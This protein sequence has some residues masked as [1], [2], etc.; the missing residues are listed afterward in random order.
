MCVVRTCINLLEERLK[1]LDG[2]SNQSEP[3]LSIYREHNDSKIKPKPHILKEHFD[4]LQCQSY[5][6]SWHYPASA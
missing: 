1:Q 5:F 2:E 4:F 3:L 6:G